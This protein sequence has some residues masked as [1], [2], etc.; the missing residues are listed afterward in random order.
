MLDTDI[1]CNSC[2]E[3]WNE[4]RD[5][6]KEAIEALESGVLSKWDMRRSITAENKDKMIQ[7]IRQG[8]NV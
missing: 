8:Y 1:E 4:F 6:P 7:W 3:L 2:W 5:N